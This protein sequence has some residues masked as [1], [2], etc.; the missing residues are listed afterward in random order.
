MTRWS[1]IF[2]WF[3]RWQNDGIKEIADEKLRLIRGLIGLSLAAL[4][5][6]PREIWPL[7][8][9]LVLIFI[10]KRHDLS[11][12]AM[13]WIIIM[14]WTTMIT[15]S[16]SG[17]GY[18]LWRGI[19]LVL[20]GSTIGVYGRL[21]PR[22]LAQGL[23][24]SGLPSCIVALAQWAAAVPIPP[25]WLAGL[26]KSLLPT[27]VMGLF[28]NPNL[29]AGYL[30][31]LQP[32]AWELARSSSAYERKFWTVVVIVQTLVIALT[33]SY[34][35]W[36]VL[37]LQAIVFLLISSERQRRLEL[38]LM[39]IAGAVFAVT[40]W[41]W[42]GGTFAYRSLIWKAVVQGIRARPL[43]VGPGGFNLYYPLVSRSVPADHAHN[44]F[45]QIT[46]E[47]GWV[48]GL[49]LMGVMLLILQRMRRTSNP[50]N[51]G[52]LLAMAGQLTWGFVDYPWTIPA[53]TVLF[54]LG[55]RWTCE[56]E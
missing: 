27:R 20:A 33:F 35:A 21:E 38:F 26:E 37:L 13:L 50:W 47:Y 44:L 16:F 48:G 4:I 54:W 1:W 32:M 45:L 51:R 17:K 24:L 43:G 41:F 14:L 9:A 52:V 56:V 31:F 10:Y 19:F 25:S 34:G 8:P 30:L 28:G 3:S 53:L 12:V 22:R 5:A 36:F 23:V 40:G 6:F 46:F 18:A 39:S 7:G 49:L 2:S 11:R 55:E 42:I 15:P 29:L